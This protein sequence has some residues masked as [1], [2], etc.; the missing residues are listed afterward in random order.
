MKLILRNILKVES[1]DIEVGGLTV[2]TG[3]N[4]SGKSTI[5]KS[6]FS[7]IKAVNN[8]RRISKF[9]ASDRIL[10]E[11][12]YLKRIFLKAG[13]VPPVL[14]DPERLRDSL[15]EGDM[16]PDSLADSLPHLAEE[17]LMPT[18]TQ[19]IIRHR[20]DV[21]RR[22][23][24]RLSNPSAAVRDEF[25]L[26]ARC[27][28]MEPLCSHGEKHG[29][30]RFIDDTADGSEISLSIGSNAVASAN[31][32]GN[33]SVYDATYIESPLYLHILN[34]LRMSGRPYD[35]PGRDNVPYHLSDMAEKLFS[36]SYYIPD[37]FAAD[38]SSLTREISAIIGGE[39]T[40]DEKSREMFFSENGHNIPPVSVASGVKSFG[41]LQRLLKTNCISTSGILIWDEPE[42][43]LHPEWQVLFCRLI[44]ELV[45]AGIPVVISSH[46]PY[47]VQGL[48]YF[49]SAKGIEK[50]V[51]YYM[52]ESAPS[53]VRPVFH[54]VTDD[55]NRVFS[56]LASPLRDIMNVD[57]VRNSLK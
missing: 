16:Q 49:A 22:I 20:C 34:T 26:I 3:E 41:I 7:V 23:L 52:S 15:V 40:V 19:A 36:Q 21:I 10:A 4:N 13:S 30:I 42:I 50:D 5:G 56:L 51:R 54:E 28:F 25:D 35:S 18:R 38:L 39:F 53:S 46:S 29:E 8:V 57:A 1:A 2:L 24:S 11:L 27:E 55:L 48:R 6:L 17:G 45:A 9:N 31:L 47:F 32:R 43:H 33:L 44:I 37:L 12:A 14:Q